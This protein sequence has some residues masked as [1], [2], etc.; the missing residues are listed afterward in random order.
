MVNGFS[1]SDAGGDA[2]QLRRCAGGFTDDIAESALKQI[3]FFAPAM[4]P[5]RAA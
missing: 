5:T 2:K 1:E 3:R 4:I